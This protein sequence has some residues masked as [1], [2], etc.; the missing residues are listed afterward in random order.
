MKTISI[1][2]SDSTYWELQKQ[3]Q[4][5]RVNINHLASAWFLNVDKS[6]CK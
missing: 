4:K 5:K 6:K 1:K 3:S 2:V